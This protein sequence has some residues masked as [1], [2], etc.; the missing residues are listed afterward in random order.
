MSV[1]LTGSDST[2][3]LLLSVIGA[4][5]NRESGRVLALGE[6]THKRTLARRAAGTKPR[7]GTRGPLRPA[8]ARAE[9]SPRQLRKWRR[10]Q[11]RGLCPGGAD[12]DNEQPGLLQGREP[13]HHLG[14]EDS[15]ERGP[16]RAKAQAVARRF[17]AGPVRPARGGG[18]RTGGHS[19]NP[20]TAGASEHGTG[21][22]A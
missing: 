11:R 5:V 18:P 4:T 7:Q 19:A 2:E 3:Y 13:I 16:H 21:R 14:A 12:Q 6:R 15:H 9:G 8:R 17:T 10:G 1:V 22:V 20:G